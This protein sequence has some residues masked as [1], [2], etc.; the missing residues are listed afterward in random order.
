MELSQL[1][2]LH[3]R[4]PLI[5]QTGKVVVLFLQELQRGHNLLI[6]LRIEIL[7]TPRPGSRP[8]ILVRIFLIASIEANKAVL[9]P[10]LLVILHHFPLVLKT[11]CLNNSIKVVQGFDYS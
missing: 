1:L 6:L 2:L 4:L 8:S 3:L 10:L 5:N 9:V 7:A 11:A